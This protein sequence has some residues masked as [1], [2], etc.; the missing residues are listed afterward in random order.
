MMM[1]MSAAWILMLQ[2]LIQIRSVSVIEQKTLMQGDH[3]ICKTKT[4]CLCQNLQILIRN[5]IRIMPAL[6][7]HRIHGI[8]P[9]LHGGEG[10]SSDVEEYVPENNAVVDANAGYKSG[11]SFLDPLQRLMEEQGVRDDADGHPPDDK[12]RTS[13]PRHYPATAFPDSDPLEVPSAEGDSSAFWDDLS[14]ALG[15]AAGAPPPERPQP[16][17]D[18]L[19]LAAGPSCGAPVALIGLARHRARR[20]SPDDRE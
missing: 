14:A 15:P 5:Q 17:S 16:D 11:S 2:L 12:E 6:V 3:L 4:V 20:A 13:R 1:F 10:S 9:I 18:S 7:P 19:P 8:H